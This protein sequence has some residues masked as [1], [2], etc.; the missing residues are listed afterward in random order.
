MPFIID[1]L[2]ICHG[3]HLSI[4]ME[5]NNI[6]IVPKSTPIDAEFLLQ[7]IRCQRLSAVTGH[8]T[9]VGSIHAI[10]YKLGDFTIYIYLYTYFNIQS[11][12][13]EIY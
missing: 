3:H 9:S 12:V 7:Y 1:I 2:I 10:V 11:T 8:S 5:G 13:V 4:E 6:K